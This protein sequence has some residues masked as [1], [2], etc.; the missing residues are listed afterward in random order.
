MDRVAVGTLA[1]W[2]A[3][4]T[5]FMLLLTPTACIAN[6]GSSSSEGEASYQLNGDF[7]LQAKRRSKHSARQSK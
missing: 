7:H 2:G 3:C 1:L 6:Q 4:L 5:A